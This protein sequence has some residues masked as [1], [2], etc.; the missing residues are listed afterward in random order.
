MKNRAT[1]RFFPSSS[2]KREQKKTRL[3]VHLDTIFFSSLPKQAMLFLTLPLRNISESYL[4]QHVVLCPAPFFI[5]QRT[6]E[7]KVIYLLLHLR[8]PLD[9]A[10]LVILTK[11]LEPISGKSECQAWSRD[12]GSV[13]KVSCPLGIIDLEIVFNL[14]GVVHCISSS[15]ERKGA[16]S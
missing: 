2:G 12:T 7:I 6:V 10:F 13:L 3:L 4:Q 16:Y 15:T 5:A 14:K 1:Q 8:W 11:I 9:N